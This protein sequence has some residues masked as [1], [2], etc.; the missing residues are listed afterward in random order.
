MVKI[1]DADISKI[2]SSW[3]YQPNALILRKII[4]D[5]GRE[6]IQIRVN[7]GILQMESEGRPDGEKPHNSESMLEYYNSIIDEYIK[8]D[9]NTDKF[10]LNQN[11]MQE[12]DEE[13]M[14]YYHRRICFFALEDY[15]RARENAEHNLNLMDIIKK[16]CKDSNYIESHEKFRPYVLMERARGAGLESLR[17][18]DYAGAMKYVS[19]TIDMIEKFYNE[20]GISEEE[21]QKS[22]ELKILKK[23]RSKI[24]QDWEGGITEI[25]DEEG[26]DFDYPDYEE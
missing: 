22:Q 21:S 11:D 18:G 14:Q 5:D 1:M 19:D 3:N 15:G 9:G 7:L 24:H 12:L 10:I 16:H 23:W 20:R 26:E 25:D 13:I 8:R 17:H 2:L 6:K 4:G